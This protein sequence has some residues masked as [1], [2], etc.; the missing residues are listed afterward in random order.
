M[1]DVLFEFDKKKVRT[2][3]PNIRIHYS[4]YDE[5]IRIVII[6]RKRNKK[7]GCRD[8][9]RLNEIYNDIIYYFK[10]RKDCNEVNEKNIR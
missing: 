6:D 4:K 3:Y 7:N 2:N 5:E 10:G 9:S 1:N 8:S